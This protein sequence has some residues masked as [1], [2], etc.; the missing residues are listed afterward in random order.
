ML[1]DFFKKL[2]RKKE[3]SREIARA[4]LNAIIMKDRNV[5]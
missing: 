1:I 3:G 2:F 5:N 4:R